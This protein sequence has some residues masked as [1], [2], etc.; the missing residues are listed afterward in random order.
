MKAR[1]EKVDEKTVRFI[2]EKPTEVTIAQLL[3]NRKELIDK[4]GQ[5]K[6]AIENIDEI[7]TEANK[8]GIE[9]KD[10]SNNN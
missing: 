1:Y 9:I 8:L 7:L 2:I 3:S 5:I 6:K 10:D 4:F